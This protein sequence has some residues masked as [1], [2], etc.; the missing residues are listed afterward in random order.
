[1]DKI[2]TAKSG[3]WTVFS[4]PSFP[5][6]LYEVRLYSAGGTLMDKVRCDDYRNALDYRKSF[7]AIARN[8]H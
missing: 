6:G 3:A 4:G 5:S 1:M 8:T 7:N 2:T